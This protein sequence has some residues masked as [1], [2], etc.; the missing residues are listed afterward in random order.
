M[1]TL[2]VYIIVARDGAKH[3]RL[4][5]E[6]GAAPPTPDKAAPVTPPAAP[7]PRATTGVS[8]DTIDESRND[9]SPPGGSGEHG[10]E[11]RGRAR[12]QWFLS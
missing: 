7:R 9:P 3:Q 6:L 4:I 11:L 12:R 10:V 8:T 5:Q 1:Q 2:K